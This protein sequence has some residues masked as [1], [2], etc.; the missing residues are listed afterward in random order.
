MLSS[1]QILNLIGVGFIKEPKIH[2]LNLKTCQWTVSNA[3]LSL[4]ID[5]PNLV[6]L[7]LKC[8]QPEYLFLKAPLLSIFY[9]SVENTIDEIEI[10]DH[11]RVD[12]ERGQEAPRDVAH[13]T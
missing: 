11:G 6:K 9:L 10:L 7:Q 8:V 12:L 3:P 4:T 5:A 13:A 2:L 1:L